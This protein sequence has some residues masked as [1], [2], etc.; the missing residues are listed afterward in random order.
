MR[1]GLLGGFQ[2]P[3]HQ[4]CAP[5][6]P[7]APGRGPAGGEAAAWLLCSALKRG[8]PRGL[9]GLGHHIQALLLLPA[10]QL[11]EERGSWSP[12]FPAGGAGG[13]R[14]R[15]RAWGC[16]LG[17]PCSGAFRSG[18]PGLCADMGG[19]GGWQ[20]TVGAWPVLRTRIQG[21][22][23][24]VGNIHHLRHLSSARLKMTSPGAAT[25][26]LAN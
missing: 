23:G 2:H 25:G 22:V 17:L 26:L 9:R 3:A 8:I 11:L 1:G 4:V 6:A 21:Q 14:R 10:L 24:V 18:Q 12:Q 16:S 19:D 13:G 5:R 7:P 20:V 15:D